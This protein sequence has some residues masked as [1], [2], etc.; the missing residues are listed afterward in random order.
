MLCKTATARKVLRHFWKTEGGLEGSRLFRINA[1]TEFDVAVDACLLFANG[2]R[3]GKRVATVFSDLDSTSASARIGFVGGD[4]VSNIDAY[5]T[6]R[7]LDGGTS[8]YTWRSGVKHD[9]GSIME[10]T[11]D[12]HKLI[13]GFG[14]AVEIEEEYVFPLLKSSD[15]GNGRI[16]I[17]KAVLVTQTYRRRYFGDPTESSENLAVL[18]APCGRLDGRKSSIYNDRPRF[19]VFGIGSY[20]FAPWKVA[21]SGLYKNISFVVVPPCDERP[22]MVDDTCYFIP[23]QSREE[24]ELLFELLSSTAAKEFL[25]SL[26]FADSK[27]PITTDVLR[28]LSFVELARDLGR[29]D[30]LQW[31][32]RSKSVSKGTAP[33]ISLVMERKRKYRT[34]R[35]IQPVAAPS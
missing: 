8:T 4:L 24:A 29:L 10:F 11:R 19:S 23:C 18:D 3:T 12:G 27:R 7:N 9:A 16:T 6:H 35:Y 34:R 1:K 2:K 22:V 30:E 17:R 31:L 32:V 28:R 33:Q 5:Q 25:S 14:V 13:N 26:V 15:L 20:S 21:V